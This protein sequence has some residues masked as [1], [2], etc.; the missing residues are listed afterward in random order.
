MLKVRELV[1]CDPSSCPTSIST[2]SCQ[3][4][5]KP[6]RT[7]L[8]IPFPF[9]V[10]CFH[11]GLCLFSVC[12]RSH[13]N[14]IWIV[15][16]IL[17]YIFLLVYATRRAHIHLLLHTIYNKYMFLLLTTLDIH[18]QLRFSEHWV[19][20]SWWCMCS[21]RRRSVNWSANRCWSMRSCARRAIAQ[22]PSS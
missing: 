20:C 11:F 2:N 18:N 9:P 10:F 1:D 3:P 12:I 16:Y 7:Y 19:W 4:H 5:P 21:T 13:L 17:T 6:K 22:V 8:S 14:V 15:F